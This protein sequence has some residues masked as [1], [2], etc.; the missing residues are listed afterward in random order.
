M[1]FLYKGSHPPM[2]DS[3]T[4]PRIQRQC[5]HTLFELSHAHHHLLPGL[6]IV[7]CLSSVPSVVLLVSQC[8]TVMDAKVNSYFLSQ[9]HSN[10]LSGSDLAA[11]TQLY[12]NG[13]LDS[14]QTLDGLP[15]GVQGVIRDT[16]RNAVR[17]SFISLIPW[18]G[19]ACVLSIFLSKTPDLDKNM[20]EEGRETELRGLHQPLNSTDDESRWARR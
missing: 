20:N 7:C 6:T 2:R 13:G 19:V 1:P 15:S 8:F 4:R 3:G 17:W 18:V 5:P 9:I 10:M 11:L 14:L 12:E 16:F